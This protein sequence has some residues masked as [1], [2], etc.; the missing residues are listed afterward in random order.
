[1]P[2]DWSSGVFETGLE[3]DGPQWR[4]TV[5]GDWAPLRDHV[6]PMLDGPEAFYGDLM[7]V[8]RKADVRVVNFE[9]VLGERGRPIPKGGP[10]L[11][12]PEEA[13]KT[14]TAVPFNVACLANNHSRDYDD[15]SLEH[16]LALL[17]EAGVRTVGAG[18]SG[19]Q[20]TRP[21]IMDVKG[22]RL[23]I[24]DCAEGEECRSRGGAAGGYGFEP[25]LLEDHVIALKESGAADVVVVIFHGGREHTPM[26]PPYVVEWLRGV[27]EAGAD[28]VIG[29]HPHAPQ[30]IE[31]HGFT[32]IAYSVGNFCFWQMS[33]LFFR[34][35][36]YLTHLDFAG[37][38]LTGLAITPYLIEPYGVRSM[39]EPVR[40]ALM[41]DLRHVSEL[42]SDPEA[43]MA[44]WDA[45]I[46]SFG[47]D[48]HLSTCKN[49]LTTNETD[50]VQAAASL[51]NVFRTP[52]HNHLVTR[53]AERVTRGEED[54]SPQWA[55]DLVARWLT[56]PYDSVVG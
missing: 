25:E 47:P 55:R 36:G 42:L 53:A 4:M 15:E 31:L 7:P 20:A 17:H 45:F 18:M 39:P 50:R 13:L 56:L 28:A 19:E 21:L 43:V 8:L 37:P 2:I 30:G 14:L 51:L 34:R 27:A 1:M 38:E 54:T 52:A 41:A 48:A 40:E 24:L 9:C 16:T 22:V 46:D 29:H 5:G 10:N 6:Q 12:A 44:A 3:G 35:A 11:N 33:D 26:P 23:A 49:V 32:P